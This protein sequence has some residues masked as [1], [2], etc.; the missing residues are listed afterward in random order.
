[1]PKAAVKPFQP[2]AANELK[3]VSLKG[4]INANHRECLRAGNET[5]Q[6]AV[7]AGE[8]L[9]KVK[10]LVP[11]GEFKKWV[12]QF[13]DFS[14]DVAN[15]YMSLQ[16]K[17]ASLSKMER[18]PLLN[19]A[20]SITSLQKLLKPKE[21]SKSSPRSSPTSGFSTSAETAEKPAA[22]EPESEPEIKAETEQEPEAEPE[23]DKCPNCCG[24]KWKEDEDGKFC[25]KCN[26]PYGEPAGDVDDKR[27]GDM[28][29]KTIKTVE[30][31]IR[32]FDDLHTLKPKSAEHKEAVAGCKVLLKLARAWK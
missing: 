29:S 7:A 6:H 12:E 16:R 10:S 23:P 24:T 17:L 15:G 2:A 20:S 8:L 11:H 25:A 18:A 32:A 28:R 22:D 4:E 27:I 13:C 26:H 9:L 14:Y 1:M 30:A 5:I 21:N 19:T 3:A 31:A